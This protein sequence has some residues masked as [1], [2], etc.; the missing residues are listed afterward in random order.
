VPEVVR[1]RARL[2]IRERGPAHVSDGQ[3][4]EPTATQ[5]P[6]AARRGGYLPP[7]ERRNDSAG[8]SSTT[9]TGII[10]RVADNR[11][12]RSSGTWLCTDLCTRRSGMA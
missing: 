4:H 3:D 5:P 6:G 8:I 10:G 12:T 1:A 9:M 11:R 2:G 7:G